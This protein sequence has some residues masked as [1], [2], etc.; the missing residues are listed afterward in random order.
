MKQRVMGWDFE[1]LETQSKT[2][3]LHVQSWYF[4]RC[5]SIIYHR[6]LVGPEQHA[7]CA[8]LTCC[9]HDRGE[10]TPS[11]G[12]CPAWCCDRGS[13]PSAAPL[14]AAAGSAAVEGAASQKGADTLQGQI[15]A[16]KLNYTI[17]VNACCSGVVMKYVWP[18][19]HACS[20]CNLSSSLQREVVPLPSHSAFAL[21]SSAWLHIKYL[22]ED[23]HTVQVIQHTVNDITGWNYHN[24]KKRSNNQQH[25]EQI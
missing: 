3:T 8:A 9:R 5:C 17:W 20:L 10:E 12:Y 19:G 16:D 15:K 2:L 11:P 21:R 13:G 22:Q 6:G 25:P 23:K 4:Y 7:G 14:L 1:H 18:Y 24:K